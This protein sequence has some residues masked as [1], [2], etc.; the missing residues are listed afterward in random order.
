MKQILWLILIFPLTV[1]GQFKFIQS[2]NLLTPED[3]YSGSVIGIADMN[4]DGLDD[5]VR[6]KSS[7]T[8]SIEYQ[9][10]PGKTFTH[11]FI[12]D[13]A[14]YEFWNVSIADINH[15]GL[16]DMVFT[17]NEN[18]GY[19]YY[20]QR[21]GQ[22]IN[23]QVQSLNLSN[24]AYAQGA[25]LADIN[26]DGW[27]D[28]FMCSDLGA[29]RIWAN[30]QQGHIKG[31]PVNW[32]NFNTVPV[33]DNSGNY[34][35]IW[36][37]LDNDGDL[38]LY[39]AKCK[40]GVTDPTD[41][42]RINTLFRNTNGKFEEVAASAGLAFGDQSW[43]AVSGDSDN[44]GD[45][46]LF[47]MNHFSA[48]KLMIN[49]GRGI[50]TE[51]RDAGINYTAIGVQV[52]WMDL[53]NDGLL[54]LFISGSA[55]SFYRNKGQNKFELV[56]VPQLG[57]L[58]VESFSFGDLNNDGKIDL[59]ASYSLIFNEASNRRDIVWL[60]DLVNTNHFI[61][62]RLEGVKSNRSAI[63]A[64]ISLVA[65]GMR[66]TREIYAGQS[67]GI[68]ASL[69]QHFGLGNLTKIDSLIVRWPDGTTERIESP[70]PDKTIVIKEATCF[71]F[72]PSIS[73]LPDKSTFCSASDSITLTAPLTGTYL[74][75]NGSSSR[76]IVT[77]T[78]E[79]YQVQVL[80]NDGCQLNSN[81]RA[82][83]AVTSSR[84]SLTVSDSVLCTGS[85]STISINTNRFTTWNTGD[86][87]LSLKVTATGKYFAKIQNECNTINSDTINIRYIDIP[88]VIAKNDT[89]ALNG[90]AN[91]S[92]AGTSLFWFAN[93]EGGSP[94]ATGTIYHTP[95][96]SKS[97]TYY[98][99]SI[100]TNPGIG[101]KG[102]LKDF[103]SPT[104]LNAN[105]FSGKLL[106]DATQAF[107]LKSVKVYTD[108]AGLRE[109]DLLDGSGKV[110]ASSLVR[111]EKGTSRVILNFAVP[112]GF[113]LALAAN[114]ETSIKVFGIKSPLLYRTE[115]NVQFPLQSG[116]VSIYGTNAGT[117]NYY[118][119]YDWEMTY[120]D[121]VCTSERVP[122]L[123]VVRTVALSNELSSSI[124]VY[125]NPAKEKLFIDISGLNFT[126]PFTIDFINSF[127]QEMRSKYHTNGAN[128]I[129][130]N[131]LQLPEG[132]YF[133]KLRSNGKIGVIKVLLSK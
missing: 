63:G 47:I 90:K 67:Y 38:D 72:D 73:V 79:N 33:S 22:A 19:V 92:A 31:D 29:N 109:I 76:S 34:G 35:S 46:D 121:L 11:R 132:V 13:I 71:G 17:A 44:D 75:S 131:N 68:S 5:I 26:N 64:K 128:I 6:L 88:P 53:D 104:M 15:D 32:I 60:N 114:E 113:G 119:F 127:G 120:P 78:P 84:Y 118:Y 49:D 100:I 106:F 65:G 3:H 21:V 80:T 86:T 25:N 56:H 108:S 42:R 57:L 18:P 54:D 101:F 40:A 36:S 28:Y 103:V 82:L 112:A 95:P 96:L 81:I 27:L 74:W 94:I 87:G 116:P 123:G 8:L 102:G 14:S 50:F 115:G 89:V 97:T 133:L 58:Q 51:A 111:I 59:Y 126:Q 99:Q 4:G 30:D 16:N 91:L 43:T 7:H 129:E 125:P 37:D 20:S 98:A 24:L 1:K 48:C 122:V 12:G 69:T 70:F 117:S 83:E 62:V 105:S 2:G 39:V 41:P 55:H 66:Q 52:A 9:T 107:V 85:I 93:A 23:Y 124:R 77:R 61:N 45:M 10:A 110:I 130:L